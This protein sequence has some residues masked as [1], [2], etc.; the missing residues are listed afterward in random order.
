M[1]TLRMIAQYSIASLALIAGLVLMAPAA[2]AQTV[3]E[4]TVNGGSSAAVNNGESVLLE[5]Y[6]SGAVSNCSINNGVGAIST[7]SLPTTGSRTVTPPDN[8]STNYTLTCTGGSSAVTVFMNPIITISTSPN[9]PVSYNPLVGRAEF[10]VEWESRYATQCTKVW[11]TTASNPGVQ[12]WTTNA[13][14]PDRGLTSGEVFFGPGAQGPVTETVTLSI[15]CTNVVTGTQSTA[16]VTMTVSG[17][18]PPP[19]PTV[20]IWSEGPTTISPDPLLGWAFVEEL[21]YTSEGVTSC[22]KQAFYLNGTPYPSLPKGF[23]WEGYEWAGV[24]Y[25]PWVRITESTRFQVTCTQPAYTY[26]GVNYPAT[27]V[28]DSVVITVSPAVSYNRAGLPPVRVTVTPYDN[29]I[30]T[31]PLSGYALAYLTVTV[32]NAEECEYSATDHADGWWGQNNAGSKSGLETANLAETT[33]LYAYCYREFDLLNFPPGSPEYENARAFAEVEIVVEEGNAPIPPLQ[34]FI[35]GNATWYSAWTLNSIRTNMSGFQLNSGV[36]GG[37]MGGVYAA[38]RA[39]TSAGNID[40]PTN[41]NG[42]IRFPF[43]AFH[44]G[45]GGNYDIFVAYCDENDGFN[46]YTLTTDSGYTVTWRSDEQTHDSWCNNY[47]GAKVKRVGVQ[48]PLTD[49]ERI[50]ITCNNAADPLKLEQCILIGVGFGQGDGG[51]VSATPD[52]MTGFAPVSVMWMGE[53]ADWCYDAYAVAEGGSNYMFSNANDIFR[54]VTT[55]IAATTEFEITCKRERNGVETDSSSVTINVGGSEIIVVDALVQTGECIDSGT[56][57]LRKANPGER[58]GAAGVC[59]PAVDLGALSPA[60]S[61]ASAVADSVRGTYDSIDALL[62]IQNLGPLELPANSGIPYQATLSLNDTIATAF[63]VPQSR[64]SPATPVFN[65]SIAAPAMVGNVATPP[66]DSPTL[67]R[68]FDNVPFGTHELCARINLDDTDA[69]VYGEWNIITTNNQICAPVT[70]PVPPPPMTLSASRD[71][72]RERQPVTIS[73]SLN[74]TYDMTCTVRGPGGLDQTFSTTD[75]DTNP[76]S[77]SFT[78]QQLTST[79]RFQMQ[80]T[81]PLTNTVFTE[82]VIVD[83]IPR[84]FEV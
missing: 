2:S 46:D 21:A 4:L 10:S 41:T 22:T 3:V 35:Y 6:I 47:N 26:Q 11:W 66:T 75:P 50:R 76:Y 62:V 36:E 67:T 81:E 40:E 73:W 69:H 56:G 42:S 68:T 84:P 64:T 52:A 39:P 17:S 38:L 34:A 78:T 72:V 70:L 53:N 32:E 16:S 8:G 60:M 5:W 58:A 13:N 54:R 74:V 25:F 23:D 59:E 80:C 18:V 24:S 63:G 31:N 9:G 33:T 12:Q 57:V 65:D 51:T 19:A 29:P 82:E 79:S 20:D 28:T 37:Y 77:G 71:V 43:N 55:D 49:G 44:S 15:Q 61:F 83:Y 7:A 45:T 48:V 1:N 14:N 27:Q 30:Y